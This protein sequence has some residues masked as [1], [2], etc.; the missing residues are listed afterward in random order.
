MAADNWD[1]LLNNLGATK[2]SPQKDDEPIAEPETASEEESVLE[3]PV[4]P[5]TPSSS[6]L[7]LPDDYPQPK[8]SAWD[9]LASTLGVAG[10]TPPPK[11]VEK[12]KPTP[13]AK[14]RETAPEKPQEPVQ[15]EKPAAPR[16][17]ETAQA[18]PPAG[19][20]KPAQ[21]AG[22]DETSAEKARGFTGWFPFAGRRA[23]PEQ[24]PTSEP[25]PI[26][27][28]VEP[29]AAELPSDLFSAPEALLDPSDAEEKSQP[30]AKSSP[31]SEP[32]NRDSEDSDSSDDEEKPRRRRRRGGRRRRKKSA[33]TESTGELTTEATSETAALDEGFAE[34]AKTGFGAGVTD[35]SSD[36]DDSDEQDDDQEES[37]PRRRRR[38]RRRRGSG[39]KSGSEEAQKEQE[40]SADEDSEY[41][42]ST[43]ENDSPTNLMA[44]HSDED[45]DDEAVAASSHKN[46]TPWQDAIGI[47]VDANIA[48]RSERKRTSAGGGGRGG[49]G[50]G[51]RP[52]GGRRRTG[53][54]R[55]PSSS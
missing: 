43:P 45:D 47:I 4:E 41:T 51:S 32:V 3:E 33:D 52:R 18:A 27:E 25:E 11:Q 2:N 22:D 14:P 24:E 48:A 5:A 15:Q 36:P 35:K 46:I 40:E 12:P 53:S 34:K 29:A 19:G 21:T 50:R 17:V 28:T 7:D 37:K 31:E 38:R 49:A 6:S 1:D 20:T 26:A 10:A 13:A 42:E 23:K 30:A 54:G 9:S 55:G 44:P 8:P 39:S 16:P